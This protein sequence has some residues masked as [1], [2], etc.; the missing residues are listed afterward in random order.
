MPESTITKSTPSVE[1]AS[2]PAPRTGGRILADALRVHGVDRV[3][4]V[5]GE[6][7]L[8]VLDALYDIPKIQVV[9][10]RHEG[11]AANMAEADGKLTGR[12]GICFVTRGPGASHGSAGV[13][14]ASQDSTPMIL[15]IGQVAR[16]VRGREAFQEVEFRQMFAPMAKWVAEIESATRIPEYI[17]R[18]F[19]TAT[20]GRPGPVVLALPEDVLAEA[21]SVADTLP[22]QPVQAKPTHEHIEEFRAE[23]SRAERPVLIV[24]GSVWSEE[25]KKAVEKFAEANTLP[26]LAAFRRQHLFDNTHPCYAGHLGLGM[27]PYAANLVKTS[28]FVIA[29]GTRLGDIPTAGYTLL[30]PP[31]ISQRLVHIHSGAEELGRVFQPDVAINASPGLFAL[32]LES[33]SLSANPEWKKWTENARRDYEKFSGIPSAGPSSGVDL[34]EVVT[35]LSERLPADAFVANGAGNYTVWVHR[36]YK[37]RGFRTELAPTSGSMGYGVPAAIAAKLR[38]PERISVCFAGDGCFLMY[39][40]ELGTAV[41]YGAP[42]IFLVVNNG[43]YGTIRM[44]QERRFPGRVCATDLL[45]PDF[46]TLAQSFGAYAERVDTTGAFAAAFERALAS[47][48]PALLELRVDPKQITPEKRL[49]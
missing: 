6:S 41:Q 29:L 5:P 22:F 40:Q 44:H 39:P 20:S 23:L 15:F 21:A 12:P 4:C 18:A 33:L 2:S 30:R 14:T 17:L 8:D 16:D 48:K 42:V 37:Y 36:F 49:P 13:H 9:V 19:H 46:V 24:G 11:A 34:A 45:T 3:F 38:Y 47:G 28:D 26:V 43:M 1:T 31:R 32:A 25:G 27:A 35:W 10:A 7:Y